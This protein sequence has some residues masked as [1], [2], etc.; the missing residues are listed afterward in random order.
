MNLLVRLVATVGVLSLVACAHP[1]DIAPNLSTFD[2]ARAKKVSKKVAY[3]ISSEDRGK[4]VTTPGGGG[5]KVTYF[6]YRDLEPAIYK[7][8]SNNFEDVYVLKS[9]DDKNELTSKKISY[10]FVP[11]IE[12]AS[13]SSSAFTWPPT[14]FTV[15]LECRALSPSGS[16]LWQTTVKGEG[17]AT[18]SEFVK[19]F[20]LAGRRASE[21]AVLQLERQL[22]ASPLAR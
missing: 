12:T 3:Y 7:M 18:F 4:E 8:L 5:D 2:G 17:K 14:E 11:K 6:P 22:R 9:V 20:G 1:I 21:Q 15:A 19:D 13:S 16:V 10:V